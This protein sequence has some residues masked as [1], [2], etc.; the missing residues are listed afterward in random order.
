MNNILNCKERP[1]D[2]LL[3]WIEKYMKYKINILTRRDIKNKKL[4]DNAT[5]KIKAGTHSIQEL[6]F[7]MKQVRKAGLAGTNV[8]FTVMKKFHL[9]IENIPMVSLNQIDE[10]FVSQFLYESTCTLADATKKNHLRVIS[11]FFNYLDKRA[12]CKFNFSLNNWGGLRGNSGVKLPIYLND[13]EIKEFMN[14][15]EEYRKISYKKSIMVILIEM[16]LHTGMR[17]HE[18]VNIRLKDITHDEL[19]Y[20]I[21]IIGKGNKERF[22]MIKEDILK[23]FLTSKTKPELQDNEL[24]FKTKGEAFNQQ[25][26]YHHMNNILRLAKLKKGKNGP[27][28]L[29]HTFATR[30]YKKTKDLVLVQELL[31]HENINTSRIYTHFDTARLKEAALIMDDL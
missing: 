31:G 30:L 21:K 18:V 22:I 26:V 1:Q 11:N 25:T 5:V 6:D 17:V 4:L 24:L 9:Y 15:L 12:D 13:K 8:Y 10:D 16:I 19:S 7:Y 23:F 28:L 3:V 20:V 14:A 27:H 29:R 2:S